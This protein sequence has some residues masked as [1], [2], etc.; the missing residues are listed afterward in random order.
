MT[1]L[2]PELSPSA[3]TRS[4]NA[5]SYVL[6]AAMIAAVLWL[7]LLPAAIAGFLVYA[8]AR[9]LEAR[10]R[11]RSRLSQRAKA[12]AVIC[13]SMIAALI[14]AGL[15]IGIGRLVEHG[16]GLEGMLTRIA[17]VLDNV[18]ESLP[19]AVVNYVPQSVT[20][21]RVQLVQMIKEHGH[22]V[23]TLGIDGLRASALMLVG[24][25]L[26][27]MVAWSDTL[28]PEDHK[29]LAAALV[30]RLSRLT[31]AFEAVVFAQVKISA[32]NTALAAIYLL[33]ALPLFGQHVPYSKSL[34]LLTFVAGLIPVAGNLISNTAIVVMSVTA[35]LE[36][37][38]A[39]LIFL[40]VVHKLEY[41]VNARIIGSRI[42][43]RAW[44]LILALIVMEALFGVGGVIAAPVLYA[45]MKRELTDAGLIG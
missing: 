15:G 3:P 32:L 29:P 45:Y 6:V 10:L 4:I 27:A 5:V 21:L 34:I 1:M 39:S 7:H 18:R 13:V 35:S 38:V 24:L 28:D 17:D 14:L 26:G 31:D 30:N 2:P 25:I 40:V 43:A 33:G 12:I 16:H 8:L 23:S 36:L 11:E 44:E 22:Q 42:D 37:A 9:K 19:A 41:F 20:E